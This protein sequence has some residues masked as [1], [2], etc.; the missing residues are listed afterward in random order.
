MNT[1]YNIELISDIQFLNSSLIIPK[2][3]FNGIISIT[4]QS[5]KELIDLVAEEIIPENKYL[6]LEIFKNNNTKTV[7]KL[8]LEGIFLIHQI[9][10]NLF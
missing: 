5:Q 10:V 6:N 3:N 8:N 4:N 9:I 1:D 7:F 2:I